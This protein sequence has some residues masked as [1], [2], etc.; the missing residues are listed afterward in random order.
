MPAALTFTSLQEDLRA[1]LERGEVSD[2]TVYDQLPRLIN[3]AEREIAQA[4]KIEG[5]INV[6]T[7]DLIAG[8]SVYDKPDRWRRTVSMQAASGVAP[9]QS[10][11]VLY[12]R[13]Y[14]YLR[15]YWPNPS[16]QGTPKFYADYDY[17]H[18]LIVPTP[19]VNLAWEVMFWQLPAL[20]DS[21]NQTNWLTD[22]AP[23][24]LLYR[25]L[26]ECEPFLKNDSRIQVWS[27]FYMDSLSALNTQ[28]LQRVVDRS[29]VR[30]EA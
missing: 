27:K 14:E 5:F 28:D 25:A 15:S 10:R 6:V 16:V 17:S 2:T 9:N 18:W 12:P 3:Q 19:V 24:T 7:S 29:S 21:T 11:F 4:L 26:L 22:Y 1:Y 8:T 23:T 20:L 13:S 30:Q